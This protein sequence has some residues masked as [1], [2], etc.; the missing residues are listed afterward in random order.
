MVGPG[1]GVFLDRVSATGENA[2]DSIPSP[3]TN[4]NLFCSSPIISNPDKAINNETDKEY[5]KGWGSR[6]IFIIQTGVVCHACRC[7]RKLTDRVCK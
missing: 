2:A 6:Q 1:R 7:C 3:M 4:N 5:F